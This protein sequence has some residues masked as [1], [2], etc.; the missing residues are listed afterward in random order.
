M[1]H[2]LDL[3]GFAKLSLIIP[4]RD[5]RQRDRNEIADWCF[6]RYRYLFPDAEI[7]IADSGDRIFSRGKSINKGVAEATGDYIIILDA[8][9]L[10]TETMAKEIINKQPWTVAVKS[11]NYF[12][13]NDK[14]TQRVLGDDPTTINL[15]SMGIENNVSK[16]P[17]TVY[18]GV[19]A[20]PKENF[21]KFDPW[22]CAYGYEDPTHFYCMRAFHG[23]EFRTNNP[24]YH[25]NHIRTP[26]SLY[27]QKS[28][29]N[30]AY[31]DKTWKPIEDD[32]KAI[33]RLVEEKGM[34]NAY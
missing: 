7:I 20:M 33:R 14:I 18:G 19:L 4:W 9:Y 1:L 30:K 16:C 21:I 31:Y 28:Y 34:L 23:K 27:M 26:G 12:Y 6:E 32:R 24:M 11:E 22:Y 13:L 5:V 3:K 2:T 8:D 25:L 17:F 29:D 15:K 10:F